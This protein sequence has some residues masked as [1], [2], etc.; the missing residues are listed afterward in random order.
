MLN[1]LPASPNI[2]LPS[3][4][5]AL[6]SGDR[7]AP[8]TR[9][10]RVSQSAANGGPGVLPPDMGVRS[11]RR[12]AQ[13]L[14]RNALR[15]GLYAHLNPTP[16]THFLI[17]FQATL[18]GLEGIPRLLQ[19]A[20]LDVRLQ[21]ARIFSSPPPAMEFGRFLSWHRSIL[22]LM[23]YFIRLQKT[24]FRLQQPQRSLQLVAVH[25]LALIRHDF[26]SNGITRDAYSFRENKKLSDFNSLLEYNL[27]PASTLLFLT[28]RQCRLLAPLLPSF[29]GEELVLPQ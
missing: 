17:T 29:S 12:G 27:P 9:H 2:L 6:P 14:N 7:A 5:G 8:C 13:P 21:I 20:I 4:D 25:A 3:P 1:V 15:H 10:F 23:G 16:L 26:R 11:R 18:P 28:P 19:T 22:H 24:L